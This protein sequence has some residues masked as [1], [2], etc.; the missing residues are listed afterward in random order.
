[1]A[2]NGGG[3]GLAFLTTIY[4]LQI[5]F[6]FHDQLVDNFQIDGQLF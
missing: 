3:F 5:D 1:M 4:S 2:L 6:F